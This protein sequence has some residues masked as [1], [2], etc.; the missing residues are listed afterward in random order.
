MEARVTRYLMRRGMFYLFALW[1]AV[2]INYLLPRLVPKLAPGSAIDPALAQNQQ[3]G[4]AAVELGRPHES[5]WA[6]YPAYLG[7]ILH[8]DISFGFTGIQHTI[9]QAVPWSLGIALAS[10]L[11]AF[12]IGTL[13]GAVSAW[14]RGSLLDSIA[15]TFSMAL[16]SFPPYFIALGAVYL[17]AIK[18]Q[19]FPTQQGYSTSMNPNWSFAFAGSAFHHAQLP[20][21]ILMTTYLGFW[22]LSMRN[23]MINALGDNHLVLAEAKGL[24][25]AKVLRSYAARN[26]ILVPL[27]MFAAIFS[28]SIDG[29]IVV[30]KVFSYPGTGLMFQSAAQANIYPVVQALLLVFTVTV[31]AVNMAVDVVA[32]VLDPRIRRA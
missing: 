8:G 32:L 9:W 22:V 11:L 21:L 6:E 3:L 30:E 15:P 16:S 17:L 29:I 25:S 14:R 13:L 4:S 28:T 10:T 2:T 7:Q 26:A 24:S 1:G 27:T 19:L 18:W 12:A 5:I 31:L 23:V 20:V